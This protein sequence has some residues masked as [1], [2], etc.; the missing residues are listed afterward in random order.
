MEFNSADLSFLATADSNRI[1]SKLK[2]TC[3]RKVVHIMLLWQVAMTP[4][5]CTDWDGSSEQLV[6][7]CLMES[8]LHSIGF[9]PGQMKPTFHRTLA[10]IPVGRKVGSVCHLVGWASIMSGVVGWCLI[11]VKNSLN[12]SEYWLHLATCANKFWLHT[13]VA[14]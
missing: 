12:I 13:C 7:I 2:K 10:N 1:P 6:W 8:L 5:P 14:Y 9:S 11:R 3:P 4:R